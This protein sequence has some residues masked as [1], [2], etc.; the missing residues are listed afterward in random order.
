[1]SNKWW[2]EALVRLVVLLLS[3]L[4][5]LGVL[6]LQFSSETAVSSSDRQPETEE[7]FSIPDFLVMSL[8]EQTI[9]PGW[10]NLADVTNSLN[11][12]AGID[13]VVS[14]ATTMDLLPATESLEWT[15]LTPESAADTPVWQ[16]LF[17]G[18]PRGEKGDNATRWWMVYLQTDDIDAVCHS[19]TGPEDARIFGVAF[20]ND[21]LAD[22]T[23]QDFLWIV[24]SGALLIGL[25]YFLLTGG[26]A[27]ALRLWIVSLLPGLWILGLFG[28]FGIH[29]SWWTM[30]VPLQA[31]ALGTSYGLHVFHYDGYPAGETGLIGSFRAHARGVRPIVMRAALTTALG[32]STLLTSSVVELRQT[33]VFIMAGVFL[34]VFA[35][36]VLLPLLGGD[37]LPVKNPGRTARGAGVGKVFGKVA[38]TTRPLVLS[39][40]V[41][42]LL[43]GLTHITASSD[44]G[45]LFNRRSDAYRHFRHFADTHGVVETLEVVV[46][47]GVQYGYVDRETFGRV[48]SLE[49]AVASAQG[50]NAVLGPTLLL[51]HTFGR[52]V[53]SEL[54]LLPETEADIGETLEMLRSRDDRSGVSQLVSPDYRYLRMV[55]HYGDGENTPAQRRDIRKSIEQ[56][57]ASLDT[58]TF[59][60]TGESVLLAGDAYL[61]Q[62]SLDR[63]ARRYGGSLLL[64]IPVV[65]L[66]LTALDRTPRTA[67]PVMVPVIIGGL[68]YGGLQGLLGI[69]FRFAT[70]LGLAFVLGVGADD[71]IYMVQSC[72]RERGIPPYA[73]R[74]IMHT[75]LL[76]L[77]GLFPVFFSR[78]RALQEMVFLMYAGLISATLIS[79]FIVPTLQ[80]FPR[81]K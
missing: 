62:Q 12:T 49:S 3:V 4:A 75:T 6:R 43:Y 68:V 69:P 80:R 36:L 35:A 26:I 58:G 81:L 37:R 50:V 8:P 27:L 32:F 18:T 39:V 19:S 65:F 5:V 47:T 54:P 66:V 41:L 11:E 29:L 48:A 31:I 70:I 33:G 57:V 51:S 71:A 14:P 22:E 15:S 23:R 7:L 46:D 40:L 34:S 2:S 25:A 74:A 59:T 56:T 1:M 45:S 42:L 60:D 52:L 67:L 24:P 79:L 20:F 9:I 17:R 10:D 63:S 78:F 61:R 13:M 53:G 64:F 76:M 72:L 30:I 77:V 55:V 16:V 21:L 28:W 73:R 38:A 44:L